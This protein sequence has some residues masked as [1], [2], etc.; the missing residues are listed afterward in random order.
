MWLWL[1]SFSIP[2]LTGCAVFYYFCIIV[3]TE[4]Q[5]EKHEKQQAVEQMWLGDER[6]EE[7]ASKD[8][9]TKVPLIYDRKFCH[10]IKNFI[11]GTFRFDFC[12]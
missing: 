4:A 1:L 8:S 12:V 10:P 7:I 11:C 2:V 5:R 6:A 3:P 9:A